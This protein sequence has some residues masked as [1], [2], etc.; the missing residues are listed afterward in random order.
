M[1]WTPTLLKYALRIYGPYLGAGV[2]T[3]Y[4]ADD[5]HEAHVQ[6][7]LRWYNTNAVGTHFGGSLY[8]MVD[9]QLMLMLLQILGPEYVVWD[10]ASTIEFLKPGRGMVKAVISV[11]PEEV[12]DIRAKTGGGDKHLP[13]FTLHVTDEA[14]EPVAKVTKTLYVR[15]KRPEPPA[16]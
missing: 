7:R 14:G 1:K 5:W 8:C 3:T 13:V 6:M 4:I 15:K 11:T 12:A 2:K 9:P 16:S 10:K